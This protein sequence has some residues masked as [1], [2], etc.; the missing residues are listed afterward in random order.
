MFGSAISFGW[1][2][3]LRSDFS[4]WKWKCWPS[5]LKF[6][7]L[8][9]SGFHWK[10]TC[11]MYSFQFLGIKQFSRKVGPNF[12][13]VLSSL[14]SPDLFLGWKDGTQ[15][16]F[17]SSEGA[18]SCPPPLSWR[19]HSPLTLTTLIRNLSCKELHYTFWIFIIAI[20]NIWNQNYLMSSWTIFFTHY[21]FLESTW[22]RTKRSVWG[23]QST[24]F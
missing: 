16:A 7:V 12:G 13:G 2:S 15:P 18:L 23:K 17:V 22:L 10:Y 6:D 4:V 24:A 3:S 11:G 8:L 1:C 9:S 14:N 5:L 19:A 21:L 20:K